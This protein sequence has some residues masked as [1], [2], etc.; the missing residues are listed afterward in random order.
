MVRNILVLASLG[1]CIAGVA[2]AGERPQFQDRRFEEDWSVLLDEDLRTDFSDPIKFVPF[3][4]SGSV[5]ASFGGQLRERVEFWN[6]FLFGGSMPDDDDVFLL[7]RLRIHGDLH[8]TERFRLFAELKSALST[9]RDLAGGK[10]QLD[11]DKA[12]LQNGFGELNLPLFGDLELRIRGG[13]QE[14]LF[15][16]ERLVSPLDWANTRRTF[17]GATATFSAG[18]WAATGF[19][20]KPVHVHKHTANHSHEQNEF[21]GTYATGRVPWVESLGLDLYW[22]GTHTKR[23]TFNGTAGKEKRHTLGGRVWGALPGT[24]VEFDLEGAAQVGSVSGRDIEAS[25]VALQLQYTPKDVPFAPTLGLG[26]DYAS[27]D[28]EA[29]GEVGTF[30]QLFPLGHAYLGFL[31]FV[32][33]QNIIDVHWTLAAKPIAKTVVKLDGHSFWRADRDDALYNAGGGVAR[34]G[35]LGNAKHVG[36]ELDLTVKR[37][38]VPHV[39]GVAGYSHFF[40]G[41]FIEQSGPDQDVDWSYLMLIVTF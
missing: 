23:A 12:A 17:D 21:F 34:A 36:Y 10:R 6:D 15:G 14:L 28:D 2:H 25:M 26:V 8:V 11:V 39:V 13:R 31:D 1:L 41:S 5:W 35:S 3:D 4:E 9:D 33:R 40:A 32:G 27:G 18:D 37:P 30:N 19:W 29:G 38:L 16:K 20:T 24:A 7:H 22:F